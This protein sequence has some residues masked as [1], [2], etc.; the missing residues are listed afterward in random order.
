MGTVI[1]F[2]EETTAQNVLITV[3]GWI[4]KQIVRKD[5]FYEKTN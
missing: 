3:N 1:P 5:E 2:G 4:N